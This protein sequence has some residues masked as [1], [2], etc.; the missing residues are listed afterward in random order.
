MTQPLTFAQQI[1]MLARGA[2]NPQLASSTV[3][4]PVPGMIA[5]GNIDLAKRP[6]VKNKDG[7]ISTVRSMSINEDGKEVLIPTVSNEGKILSD[8]DAVRYYRRTGQHLGMF[9]TPDA[10]DAYAQA[11]HEQ[12]AAYYGAGKP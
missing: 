1:A 12:Q 2:N 4:P 10:A 9:E 7:S 6:V 3:A 8:E 5:P 11:L